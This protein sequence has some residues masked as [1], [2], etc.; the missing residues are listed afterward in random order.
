MNG[1]AIADFVDPGGVEH[2]EILERIA[3]D[4]DQVGVPTR[5]YAAKVVLLSQ[6]S[7]VVTGGL[8]NDFERMESRLLVQF[9]AADQPEAVHLVD[10][11]GIV[12]H[13]D[14]AAETVELA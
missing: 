5:A 13:A 8:L 6:D 11:S 1:L 7:G 12:T 10:E 3:V 14:Q 2:L 4:D 9:H